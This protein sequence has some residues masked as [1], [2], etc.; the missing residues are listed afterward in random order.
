[1]T[2]HVIS[3]PRPTTRCP[4]QAGQAISAGSR[5]VVLENVAQ[6]FF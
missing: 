1:M 5:L 3:I 6:F 4:D 2:A